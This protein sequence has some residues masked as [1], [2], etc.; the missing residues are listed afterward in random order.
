MATAQT[1]TFTE[2]LGAAEALTN[3]AR[4]AQASRVTVSLGAAS[5]ALELIVADN[6]KG[7]RD[8]DMESVMSMG[9]TGMRER[10]GALGG[11]VDIRPRHCFAARKRS[12]L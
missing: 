3:V 1:E 12:T 5:D 6:G 8:E 7:I 4:H 2:R 10:A 9:L 11:R